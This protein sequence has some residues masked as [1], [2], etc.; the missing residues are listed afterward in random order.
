MERLDAQEAHFVENEFVKGEWTDEI[1][2]AMLETR[3]QSDDR[4]R[5]AVTALGV[6]P[7][8]S[9]GPGADPT[10]PKPSLSATTWA[11]AADGSLEVS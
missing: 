11:P 5:L 7:S 9:P 1:V 2:Y 6:S 8:P 10:P 3:G 4:K